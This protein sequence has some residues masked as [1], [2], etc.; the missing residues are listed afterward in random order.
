[1]LERKPQKLVAPLV[2]GLALLMAS[3][4]GGSAPA[5]VQSGGKG[6]FERRCGGCHSL[7]RDKEGPRLRDVFGRTAGSVES[8]QYSGALRKSGIQWTEDTLDQWLTDTEKLVPGSD[9]AF[10]VVSADE[11]T[12]IIAYLKRNSRK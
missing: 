10:R 8:F 6:L 5:Q 1:M 7:D 3:V 2:T 4:V 9:M 12:E 11:R